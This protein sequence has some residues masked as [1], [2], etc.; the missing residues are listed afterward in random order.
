MEGIELIK[1]VNKKKTFVNSKGKSV[2]S[3][4]YCICIN[5]KTIPFKP[6]F[7]DG[8]IQLDLISKVVIKN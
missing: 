3:Y 5:G 2:P 4:L 1:I 6:I 8:Y 7:N